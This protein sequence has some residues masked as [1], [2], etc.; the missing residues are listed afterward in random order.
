MVIIMSNKAKSTPLILSI[1][2]FTVLSSWWAVLALKSEPEDFSR[3][4]FGAS[5][6]LMALFGGIYGVVT[7]RKW[8]SYKSSLGRAILFLACGLLLA[9]FGQLVFSYY[10]IIKKELVPYPSIADIGFFGNMYFYVLG[11]FALTK[12][13][14]VSNQIKKNPRKLIVGIL[15]PTILLA[16]TYKVFLTGYDTEG[17]SMLQKILDFGYPL[18][19]A[20]YVSIALVA[21][22]CVARI[23]GGSMRKPLMLLLFAFIIQ[24][25]ADF[26]FLYQIS[27]ETWV[28]GGYGD[29]LY[30]LAYFVMTVSLIKIANVF[31]QKSSNDAKTVEAQ[32]G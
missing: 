28:N 27:H 25:V 1:V 15:L 23:L 30:L 24:Y 6:G 13:L 12:V 32:N 26:N 9:E 19:D 7:S 18:G 11:G 20:I 17:V 8:G 2:L 31:S 22:L 21:L 14:G 10:N 29:Y 3:Y 16:S 4:I 5:Y